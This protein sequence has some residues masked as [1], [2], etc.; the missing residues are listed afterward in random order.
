MSSKTLYFALALLTISTTGCKKDKLDTN[1]SEFQHIYNALIDDGNETDVTW[2]A[3]VH[4]YQFTLSHNRTLKSIGYQSDAALSSTDYV[5][6]IMKNADSS[7][8]Y[9]AGH[10]FSS[11]DI[12]YVTPTSTVSLQSGV[13][14]TLSRIQTNWGQYITETVG[15]LVK[16]EAA[17]FP[18]SHGDLTITGAS[19]HDFGSTPNTGATNAALPRIDLVFE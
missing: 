12:S 14:Y 5:I 9:S 3:E 17:D 19:F 8:V 16:T 13:S 10:R 2:D 6:E 1:N 11:S 7:I 4:A 15:H 18:I